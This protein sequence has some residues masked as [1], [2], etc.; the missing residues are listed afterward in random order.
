[1]SNR[2][3]RGVVRREDAELLVERRVRHELT[4]S[5]LEHCIVSTLPFEDADSGEPPQVRLAAPL[6]VHFV[7]ELRDR[8]HGRITAFKLQLPDAG[9]GADLRLECRNNAGQRDQAG[10]HI[11][12][13]ERDDPPA[14]GSQ[15]L[16]IPHL[17]LEY[18]GHGGF[19]RYHRPAVFQV[20]ESFCSN[21]S[22]RRSA[23]SVAIRP[24]TKGGPAI[25]EGA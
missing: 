22:G 1:E 7:V 16:Y 8:L 13:A 4:V 24:T 19:F 11:D 21:S 20:D 17:R 15:R 10:D 9:A 12:D 5:H 23:R 25:S 2:V 14:P 18:T 6:K 3:R